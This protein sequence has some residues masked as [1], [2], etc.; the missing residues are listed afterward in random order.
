MKKL[1]VLLLVAA[2]VMTAG[3][4]GKKEPEQ[5][6]QDSSVEQASQETGVQADAEAAQKQAEEI[7]E[8]AAQ[9][10]TA[11]AEAESAPE[12]ESNQTEEAQEGHVVHEGF[13][14][15]EEE[16]AEP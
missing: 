7:A 16:E 2:M 10:A 11:D 1:L 8:Q 14:I 9:G 12:T 6:Q 13:D 4:K 3:C 15:I 5:A